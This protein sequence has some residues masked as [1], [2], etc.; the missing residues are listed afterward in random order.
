MKIPRKQDISVEDFARLYLESGNPV[1]IEHFA[2]NWPCMEWS[3]TSLMEKAG[4]SLVH[5]RRNTMSDNYKTGRKY[6]IEEMPF[7]EYISNLLQNNKKSMDSYLAV[8]NVKKAF[9]E[10]ESDIPIPPYVGKMHGGPFLWIAREGHYEFCHFDPDDGFLVMISGT[11][12][13]RLYGCDVRTMYPNPLGSKGK[14]VQSQVDCDNPDLDRF[15]N[16][17]E[18]VC[19]EV[20]NC[21]I[22]SKSELQYTAPPLSSPSH[23]AVITMTG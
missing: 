14:T 5:V 1:I 12:R 17:T 22:L 21:H 2:E 18:A 4:E 15:P 16:F 11:K 3:L 9:P 13:V 6:N 7:R 23:I 10:L 8:Q 20:K 19:R